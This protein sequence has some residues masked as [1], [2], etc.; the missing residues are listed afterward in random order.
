M[1]DVSAMGRLLVTTGAL[2]VVIG[3]LLMFGGKSL[4]LGRLP[5]DFVIRKE[6]FSLY[7]PL[8]SSLLISVILSLLLRLFRR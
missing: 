8:A 5:G 3:L 6:S 2:L 4:P 7:L 1:G